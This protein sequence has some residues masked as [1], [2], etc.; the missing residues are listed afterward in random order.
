[1]SVSPSVSV[2]M[3]ILLMSVNKFKNHN[4][5]TSSET[6]IIQLCHIHIKIR[7]F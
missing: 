6:G 1:M 7:P 3:I 4:Q 5:R 2:L